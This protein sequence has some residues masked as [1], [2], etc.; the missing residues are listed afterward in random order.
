MQSI[1]WNDLRY[2]LVVAQTGSLT[3]AARFLRVT[4]S[5]VSRRIDE[6]ERA[7]KRPLFVRRQTGY[8]LSEAGDALLPI[9][10]TVEAR[11][12]A[13][14]RAATSSDRDIDGLS[15]SP[16]R[17]S[18][19]SSSC[20]RALLPS[21]A[22]CLGCVST[23]SRWRPVRLAQQEA[24]ILLRARARQGAYKVRHVGKLALGLFG[25]PTYWPS[26]RAAHMGRPIGARA[27][28]LGEGIT[29]PGT[30]SLV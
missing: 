4:P 14:E 18:S 2:F 30:C 26:T 16:R 21:F 27:H 13:F 25:S 28:R 6:L 23:S 29:V 8:R 1:D 5:T 17:S 7:I 22:P 12:L 3:E 20:C 9:A 19:G 11:V 15:A 10:E 24:D